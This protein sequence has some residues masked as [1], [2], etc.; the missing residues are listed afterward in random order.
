ME[1]KFK[2]GQKVRVTKN[3]QNASY[4]TVKLDLPIIG[5]YSNKNWE[6][7]DYIILSNACETNF[8][9]EELSKYAYP[10]GINNL[11]VGFVC[12]NGLTEIID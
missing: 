11:L 6:N 4:F 12:E 9:C 10:L 1:P 3:G 2:I 5:V 8:E 7:I